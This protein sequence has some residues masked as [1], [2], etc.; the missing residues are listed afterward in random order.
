MRTVS[1]MGSTGSIG[2]Q[3]LDVVR[4][5][6]DRFRVHALAAQRS[7]EALVAQAARVPP[8]LRGHRRPRPLRDGARRRARGHRGAGRRTRAWSRRP[9]RRRRGAQRR[10]RVRRTAGDAGRARGRQ[11]AGPGQQGVADRRRARGAEGAPHAGRRDRPGRLRALRAPPVPGL[12]RRDDSDVARLLA[13]R[14]GWARSGAG[15]SSSSSSVTVADA[16]AH[17]TWSMGPKITVD[18]STLMNKGLEVIEAHELFGIDYDRI[19]I[20]VHPQSDRALH[21]RAARRVDAGPAGRAPTCGC[22]SATRWAGPTGPP[23]PSGRSTGPAPRTL[24]FEPP[25]RRSSVASTWPMRP[26]AAAGP[27]RPG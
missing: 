20:V 12:G 3:A 23:R 11:A 25:D 2:T 13:D 4:R 16:L 24:T 9:G 27:L 7:A 22:P 10:R 21:G 14:V 5:E 1:L 26:G 6:P 19:D 8:R 18:S 17:P 15:R